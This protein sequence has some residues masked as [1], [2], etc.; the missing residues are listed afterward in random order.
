MLLCFQ[1]LLC[2]KLCQQNPPRPNASTL[3][4]VCYT[5][6]T[7]RLTTNYY[8]DPVVQPFPFPPLQL[9]IQ[10]KREERQ[11][12]AMEE[13]RSQEREARRRDEKLKHLYET[14]RR[15]VEANLRQ[16]QKQRE[17]IS[18]AERQIHIH[19]HDAVSDCVYYT[20]GAQNQLS[21]INWC[22]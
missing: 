14:Q 4:N 21:S 11:R 20:V 1:S 19:L 12:K 16:K 10:H 5:S 7:T 13:Q 6:L 8:S 2:S 22:L 15:R 18:K 9:Y 3:L 17:A